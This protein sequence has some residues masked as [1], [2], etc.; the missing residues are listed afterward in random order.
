[1]KLLKALMNMYFPTTKLDPTSVQSRYSGT[2][3]EGGGCACGAWRAVKRDKSKEKENRATVHFL[4]PSSPV[5][6]LP[7]GQ[8]GF[9]KRTEK[10]PSGFVLHL[11]SESF[12]MKGEEEVPYILRSRTQGETLG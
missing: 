10:R 11:D 1:M 6:T 7:L 9:T 8:G 4:C 5:L 3:S 12:A 2:L